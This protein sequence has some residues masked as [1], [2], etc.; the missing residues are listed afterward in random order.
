MPLGNWE[1]PQWTK[2]FHETFDRLVREDWKRH[3]AIIA[4]NKN[5]ITRRDIEL[6]SGSRNNWTPCFGYSQSP[7]DEYR[8]VMMSFEE[9][10]RGL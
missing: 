6:A 8:G 5:K 7:E 10:E 4:A 1:D 9:D 3:D 2:E